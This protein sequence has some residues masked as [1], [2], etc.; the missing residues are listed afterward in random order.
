VAPLCGALAACPGLSAA[1]RAAAQVTLASHQHNR[2]ATRYPQVLTLPV[3][4]IVLCTWARSNAHWSSAAA[5]H[6][7][8]KQVRNSNHT[9]QI[10]VS[11]KTGHTLMTRVPP[12]HLHGQA[13][14]PSSGPQHSCTTQ[15]HAETHARQQRGS[16]AHVEVVGWAWSCWQFQHHTCKHK[17]TTPLR[18]LDV[19]KQTPA[20][21]AVPNWCYMLTD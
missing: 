4:F 16:T 17:C 6:T 21:H 20:A 12:C 7:I 18:S 9:L 5:S 19:N 15:P 2:Q 10:I 13:C 8:C 3:Q 11:C 1:T 14:A